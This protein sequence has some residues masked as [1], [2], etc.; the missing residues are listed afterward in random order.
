[1]RTIIVN[2]RNIGKYAHYW[3]AHFK[4]RH[5]IFVERLGWDLNSYGGMEFDEFDTPA[6]EYVLCINNADEVVGVSRLLP[7]SCT[8]MI[9]KSFSQEYDG[10]LPKSDRV[11][12]ATRFGVCRSL[13][14][15]ERSEA[16]D[17][18]TS[19]IYHFGQQQGLSEFLLLMPLFIY[20]RILIPRG[21]DLEVLGKPWRCGNMTIAVARVRIEPAESTIRL[22]A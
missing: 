12:E 6:T 17:A 3:R 9:E 22:T 19:R 20:A 11:W 5:Q 13:S 16:I 2:N 18:I 7:T 1:M 10:P 14:G 4:L 15:A 8:Y 21:Y